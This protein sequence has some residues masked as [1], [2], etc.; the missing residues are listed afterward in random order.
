MFP[1]NGESVPRIRFAG[2]KCDWKS[3]KAVEI[4]ISVSDK[5][6][7][8]LPVL[9]ASQEKGMVL[10][11]EIGIDIKFDENT[12]CTYKRIIPGQFAIHLRSFQGGF[13]HSILEGI[14]SP[15]YTILDFKSQDQHDSDFWKEI[16]VSR[17]F[18]KRL[19]SITYGIRD[20]RSIGFS[21]FATLTVSFPEL[22]EQTAIG[23]FFRKLDEQI[24]TYQAKLDKLKQLKQTFLKKMFA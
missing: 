13:A 14:T 17:N 9:S 11:D 16:F 8:H 2:F 19:E 12:L 4:F 23:T 1:Q 20:G 21:E 6:H 24:V 10:R 3:E 5:N 15:A 7:A 22:E 18:I